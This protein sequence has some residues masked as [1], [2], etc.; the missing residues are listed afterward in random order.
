MIQQGN[1]I[2]DFYFIGFSLMI[3]TIFSLRKFQRK[4]FLFLTT[5]YANYTDLFD[6]CFCN[7]CN[8]LL[9]TDIT[10]NL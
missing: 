5:D 8:L 10:L 4:V 9:D 2:L 6:F 7:L 1:Q 3:K